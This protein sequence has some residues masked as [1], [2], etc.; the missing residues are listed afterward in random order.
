M[1]SQR[2]W[3]RFRHKVSHVIL[4]L[5]IY[6]ITK[7]RYKAVCDRFK[8]GKDRE[9]TILYNHQTPFDQFFVGLSFRKV[10]YYV[11]SEEVLTM[12]ILSSIIRFLVAPI[13]IR[14]QTRDF[15][16]VKTCINIAKEGGSICIAPEG[17]TTFSGKTT[18]IEP[19]I[20]PFVRKLH[21]PLVL[22]RIEGGYGA[23]PRWT[24]V[25]RQGKVHGYVSRV[26]ETEDYDKMT[27]D[28]L[29]KIITEGLYVDEC[30]SSF[31]PGVRYKSGKR[32]E[33][34][35]R[36]LYVCPDCGLSRLVSSKAEFKCTKCN[37]TYI[38]GEDKKI[39]G[40]GFE[41]R[42]EYAGDWY[43]YQQD[44]INRLDVLQYK[45][46]PLYRD[47]CDLYEIVDR[48]R[49]VRVLKDADVVLYGDRMLIDGAVYDFDGLPPLAVQGGIKLQINKDKRLF[50]LKGNKDFNA[51]KYLNI[52]Y[53]YKNMTTGDGNGQFLGL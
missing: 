23:H 32:A 4:T 6:A 33:H 45:D 28:E 9:Y 21:L 14:K 15:T 43:Q 3:I 17:N 27:D 31:M 40:A 2:K 24:D 52:Y 12:G 22:Y 34:I 7:L 49:K 10:I 50:Q 30:K 42:F 20:V 25:T 39:T 51:V 19:S 29:Y 18:F 8:E 1:A 47:I 16:A 13:P 36:A 46:E 48:K 5:P 37:K 44:Y 38:Y 11:A 53:R 26:V 41:S 35:E